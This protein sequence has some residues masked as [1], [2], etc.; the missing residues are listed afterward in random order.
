MDL[1]GRCQFR[2]VGGRGRG[3]REH[4]KHKTQHVTTWVSKL[5]PG[6]EAKTGPPP[7]FIWPLS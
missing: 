6:P 1:L 7:D 4:T 5:R 3:T 2:E